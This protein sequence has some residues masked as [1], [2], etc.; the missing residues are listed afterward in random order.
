MPTTTVT[1]KDG[2]TL[3][4]DVRG[5]G[6]ALI[7]ITGAS[8]FRNFSPVRKDAK[9]M[10]AEFRVYTYDR[11]GRGDSGD[12]TPWAVEREVEDVEAI[13]D[14]AGGEAFLYGHSSG[15][16]LA[17]EAALSLGDKVKRVVMYD[18]PYVHDEAERAEYRRL[19]NQI[20]ALLDDNDNGNAMRTFL[21]SI[22]M[23]KMFVALLPLLPGWGQM[24]ALAPTLR[25]DIALT[26]D[27][28][29]LGRAA[30]VRT[31]TMVVVGEKSP[32]SVRQVGEQLAD[33]I[34]DAQFVRLAG[35]DHMVDAKIL[36]PRL[37]GFLT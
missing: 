31:P 29:P 22:G 10:A 11:R 33:A 32:E 6:P 9:T 23:P 28:P 30:Q 7:Y 36:T 8:C 1:S 27:L 20:D 12:A 34:P 37:A 35:Q 5:S 2:T 13:I 15:A 3:A 26:R 17:L 18:A 4:Y 19:G 25:Y 14:A 16:V 24:K 21:R